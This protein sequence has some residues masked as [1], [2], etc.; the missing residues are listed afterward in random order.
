M[1]RPTLMIDTGTGVI[2]AANTAAVRSLVPPGAA[3]PG[4]KLDAVLPQIGGFGTGAAVPKWMRFADGRRQWVLP[5]SGDLPEKNRGVLVLTA[6]PLA[7]LESEAGSAL[8]AAIGDLDQGAPLHDTLTSLCD[9]LVR[10]LDLALARVV[11]ADDEMREIA[12]SG[13][14]TI[15]DAVR[16]ATR[17]KPDPAPASSLRQSLP[18]LA[19]DRPRPLCCDP[20]LTAL[21]VLSAAAWPIDCNGQSRVLELY[22]YG[23]H[24]LEDAP[25]AHF[26]AKWLDWFGE[27][28]AHGL[29]RQQQRLLAEAL[30]EAVTP[31]F[32]ADAE[33]VIIWV[34][35]A[36]SRQYGYTPEQAIGHTPRILQSGEH[37]ERYYRGLWAAIL[38]G[39]AWSGRTVDRAADGRLFVVRQSITPLLHDGRPTHFLAI[40]SDITDDAQLASLGDAI[41]QTDAL[42]GLLTWS[43]FKEQAGEILTSAGFDGRRWTLMLIGVTSKSGAPPQLEPEAL[44]AIYAE[45]GQRIRSLLPDTALA[46]NLGGFD[47][48]ALLPQD[49]DT[50]RLTGALADTLCAPLP[51]LGDTLDLRG[52][53]ACAAF[54]DDGSAVDELRKA[55]DRRL[56]AAGT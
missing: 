11:T 17:P 42:S 13:S 14:S 23:S 7:T 4:M 45:L 25:T 8:Q 48:A 22:V 49:A 28:L 36:F 15:A 38:G 40:H 53:T 18:T 46:A 31:A 10:C 47:F 43:A 35:R 55:A 21:G 24:D 9:A 6:A 27:R 50:E 39:H 29:Q 41:R 44:A 19:R 12:I 16:N 34:N 1:D 30:T 2:V 51:M 5:V 20:S 37:G 52:R 3:L 26:L 56:A 33:G 32:I 54:P